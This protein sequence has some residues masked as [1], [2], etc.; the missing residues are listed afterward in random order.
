MY[1]VCPLTDYLFHFIGK[2]NLR[3]WEHIFDCEECQTELE[4]AEHR[5]LSLTANTEY[6]RN[7]KDLRERLFE[8]Y[9]QN[10]PDLN[11]L[12]DEVEMIQREADLISEIP[13][14]QFNETYN[15]TMEDMYKKNATE[16]AISYAK[17]VLISK[18]SYMPALFDLATH[19][20]RIE[21]HVRLKEYVDEIFT[22]ARHNRLAMHNLGMICLLSD[23]FK[24][25]HKCFYF[26]R[27]ETLNSASPSSSHKI[28]DIP[29]QILLEKHKEQPHNI[30]ILVLIGFLYVNTDNFDNAII[31][32]QK[33]IAIEPNEPRAI[34]HLGEAYYAKTEWEIALT[35]LTRDVSPWLHTYKILY[36]ATCYQYLDQH[37][38]AQDTLLSYL[39]KNKDDSHSILLLAMLSIVNGDDIKAES[40]FDRTLN[41]MPQNPQSL[42]CITSF[43]IN[44][45][46]PSKAI[47]YLEALVPVA[48]ETNYTAKGFMNARLLL[49]II[50]FV[51]GNIEKSVE[52]LKQNH[53]IWPN[54]KIIPTLLAL[55]LYKRKH[56]KERIKYLKLATKI[57]PNDSWLCELLGATYHKLE[58][59]PSVDIQS[60]SEISEIDKSK[61]FEISRAALRTDTV[62][63]QITYN[64]ASKKPLNVNGLVSSR[65]V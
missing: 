28:S 15:L 50:Y 38:K 25:A 40:Y 1:E 27:V 44:K 23:A 57:D 6:N 17:K 14:K 42:F 12:L 45:N 62:I 31:Y 19:Y 47:K 7:V 64:I 52:Y 4:I 3:L 32:L 46:E 53:E 35:Y 49:G 51:L 60:D 20:A 24:E 37:N 48:N 61:I 2:G 63:E 18:P 22:Y 36:I 9:G 5:E 34:F 65:V 54:T 29:I 26:E 41:I 56:L 39:D 33:A 55:M 11:T 10:L 8:A 43:F 13:D 58:E 59:Q 21:N 30:D 16:E